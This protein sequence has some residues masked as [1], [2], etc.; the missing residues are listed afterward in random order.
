MEKA[1]KKY[2]LAFQCTKQNGVVC[3]NKT[4]YIT[5]ASEAEAKRIVKKYY[6]D[7]KAFRVIGKWDSSTSKTKTEKESKIKESPAPKPAEPI[8]TEN[9]Y[10]GPYSNVYEDLLYTTWKKRKAFMQSVQ[11]EQESKYA[12]ELSRLTGTYEA[13]CKQLN[14]ELDQTERILEEKFDYLG[15]LGFFQLEKKNYTI[16]EIAKLKQ[17]LEEIP[18]ELEILESEFDARKLDLA[19][20]RE[21]AD[22]RLYQQAKQMVPTANIKPATEQDVRRSRLVYILLEMD[23]GKPYTI[24]E[25]NQFPEVCQC[26][27]SAITGLFRLPAGIMHTTRTVKQ[28]RAYYTLQLPD[29]IR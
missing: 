21:E 26:N 10:S 25:L 8:K 22:R 4:M 3:R 17:R 23:P 12:K 2:H 5:A 20:D 18:R 27:T 15:T 1:K 6:P 13:R 29:N 14:K 9:A 24:S 19:Y 11:K 28:G 7:A 16:L